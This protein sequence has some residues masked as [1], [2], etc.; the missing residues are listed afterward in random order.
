MQDIYSQLKNNWETFIY[1]NQNLQLIYQS[2]LWFY[3][4]I[5]VQWHQSPVFPLI[6]ASHLRLFPLIFLSFPCHH[7]LVSLLSCLLSIFPSILLF[8]SYS[9]LFYSV[10]LFISLIWLNVVIKHGIIIFLL[11]LLSPSFLLLLL[12]IV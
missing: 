9:I 7:S 6:T 10:L 5:R 8:L 12:F 1:Q 3:I 4:I 11:F 2:I